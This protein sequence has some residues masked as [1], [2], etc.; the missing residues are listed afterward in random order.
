MSCS[1]ASLS[2]HFP[3]LA[4]FTME[5]KLCDGDSFK[6]PEFLESISD[7]SDCCRT[8]KSRTVI[9][10][11]ISIVQG[12]V[13]RTINECHAPK[14]NERGNAIES[15]NPDAASQRRHTAGTRPR[16]AEGEDSLYVHDPR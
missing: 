16:R 1:S 7:R 15:T 5:L 3:P 14:Q 4:P 11:C 2:S 13:L 10:L 8:G 9:K 6:H 12:T